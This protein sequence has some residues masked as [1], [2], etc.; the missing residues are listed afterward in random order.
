MDL[1]RN[2][3]I[4]VMMGDFLG[5]YATGSGANWYAGTD[6]RDA[7][8]KEN[9]MNSVR[10]M[11]MEFKDEPYILMWV[12]G[13][14]NNYGVA[15][16]ANKF[17]ED[18]YKFVNEVSLMIKSIDPDHPVAISN[19]ETQFL[20]IIARNCPDI[21][22]FGCNSYRGSTGFEG[23]LFEDVKEVYAKPVIITEYGCPAYAKDR[24]RQEAEESQA[25]YLKATWEG[26]MFS[27]AGCGA[28]NAIG[29]VLFEWLDEWWKAYEPS[30]HDYKP[31][32][33]GPFPDGWMHEEWLGVCS[34]G[35]GSDSPYLR[36]LRKSYYTYQ[37]LW[38]K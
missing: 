35:D 19:G 8:Q 5:M 3:G 14:E 1:Y 13:N 33:A 4:M 23:T 32:W 25:E 24:S 29:G 30:L 9:M 20:E 31:L 36:Q 21:D 6:Y 34:Q 16:N 2:Y 37:E 15:C 11:V 17:P 28:G 12:L 38:K 18:Y 7:E 26:I 10:N 27:T 22:I